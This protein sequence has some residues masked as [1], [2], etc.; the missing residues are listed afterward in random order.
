[1]KTCGAK[2]CKQIRNKHE[3]MATHYISAL[4]T[5]DC[6]ELNNYNWAR[7]TLM[8]DESE[9]S[10]FSIRLATVSKPAMTPTSIPRNFIANS[11]S[12]STWRQTTSGSKRGQTLQQ[13][14]W[15]RQRFPTGFSTYWPPSKTRSCSNHLACQSNTRDV[16]CQSNLLRAAA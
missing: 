14:P 8:P 9:R 5:N 2:T 3:T 13:E 15:T 11:G 6:T 16:T 12:S 7:F 4:Q 10:T 1:M